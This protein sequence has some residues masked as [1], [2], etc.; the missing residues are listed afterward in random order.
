MVGSI[1]RALQNS[2]LRSSRNCA[3]VQSCDVGSA[4]VGGLSLVGMDG[5]V[6][7]S[8]KKTGTAQGLNDN[9][10]ARNSAVSAKARRKA[11]RLAWPP[12]A[13]ISLKLRGSR[14]M[15]NRI[16]QLIAWRDGVGFPVKYRTSR[17]ERPN[18]NNRLTKNFKT[19]RTFWAVGDVCGLPE[20]LMFC[21][22]RH[23]RHAH[24]FPS[25]FQKTVPANIAG[26]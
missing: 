6:G 20:S 4:R 9:K 22:C 18:Q 12:C 8:I 13:A 1:P 14:P 23:P 25:S 21:R 3:S 5:L 10:K 24:Y 17:F 11:S 2:M 7:G 26:S 15:N 16:A 19:P